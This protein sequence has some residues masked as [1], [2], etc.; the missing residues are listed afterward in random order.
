MGGDVEFVELPY[1]DAG[2]SM[3]VFKPSSGASNVDQF[4]DR[5]KIGK[6]IN[7]AIQGGQRTDIFVSIP[8]MLA[9]GEYQLKDVSINSQYSNDSILS[10]LN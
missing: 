5:I 2:V 3:F 4:L 10:K 6:A 9:V 8:K 1:A 7:Q